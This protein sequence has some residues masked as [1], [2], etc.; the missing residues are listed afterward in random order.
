MVCY[1]VLKL[2]L[3]LD[4]KNSVRSFLFWEVDTRLKR[5][6]SNTGVTKKLNMKRKDILSSIRS[7]KSNLVGLIR[8]SFWSGGRVVQQGKITPSLK[9]KFTHTYVNSGNIP[10]SAKASLILLMSAF[11]GRKLAYLANIV[12]LLKTIAWELC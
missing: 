6:V 5:D 8:G 12:P 3:L 11:F 9:L 4:E 7:F 2:I 10:F 1:K